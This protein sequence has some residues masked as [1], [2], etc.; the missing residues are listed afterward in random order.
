M[1]CSSQQIVVVVV[2]VEENIKLQPGDTKNSVTRLSK[3]GI[4]N[5]EETSIARQL[6]AEHI[7][8]TTN[9]QAAVE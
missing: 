9:T 1:V 4:V 7:P 2:V 3:A 6:L 5:S 8:L